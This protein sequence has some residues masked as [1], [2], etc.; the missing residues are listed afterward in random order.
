MTISPLSYTFNEY[1]RWTG[2][3]WG[4]LIN[5]CYQPPDG[6]I[7]AVGRKDTTGGWGGADFAIG[8]MY[9]HTGTGP[10]PLIWRWTAPRAMT[11][12]VTAS[13]YRG[14]F[15]N[16]G[17]DQVFAVRKNNE[18]P[19]FTQLVTWVENPSS[20]PFVQVAYTTVAPGDTLDYVGYPTGTGGWFGMT[21]KIEEV[22][23]VAMP[24]FSPPSGTFATS[25]Q[26][27]I[28]C[29]TVGAAI[30]YTLDGSTPTASSPLYT[31]PIT[32]TATT[33]VKAIGTLTGVPDSPVA[34]A[35]YTK[36]STPVAWN[37]LTDYAPGVL[38]PVQIGPEWAW[39][40]GWDMDDTGDLLSPFSF[41]PMPYYDDWYWGPG[42]HFSDVDPKL[43]GLTNPDGTQ[44]AIHTNSTPNRP[45]IVRW[46]ARRSFT[47]DIAGSVWQPWPNPGD[48]RPQNVGIRK[49][50]GAPIASA[51]ID[52]TVTSTSP[53]TFSQ[54]GIHVE[55]GDVLDF[56]A[57]PQPGMSGHFVSLL[58]TVNEVAG[59]ERVNAPIFSP[60]GGSYTTPQTVTI[61]CPDAA[62]TIHYTTNGLDPT[63]SDPVIASGGTVAINVTTTL[64]ARAFK[65]GWTPSDVTTAVYVIQAAAPVFDPGAGT[66]VTSAQIAMSSATSGAEIRYTT[67]GSEPGAGSTLYTGPVTL[68]ATTT[69]KAKAFK[70]GLDPSPTTSA[71]YT[72][73]AGPVTWDLATD[74]VENRIPPKQIG[75]DWAW[76]YGWDTDTSGTDITDPFVFRSYADWNGMWLGLAPGYDDHTFLNGTP[77]PGIG[78]N[79]GATWTDPDWPSGKVAMHTPPDPDAFKKAA[80][81][82][83]TARRPITVNISGAFW[84]ASFIGNPMRTQVVGL[85]K[86]NETPLLLTDDG[87]EPSSSNPHTFSFTGVNVEPGDNLDFFAGAIAGGI[88]NIVGVDLTISEVAGS[89]RVPAPVINPAG[90]TYGHAVWVTITS[91][92]P[93]ATV[94]YTTD[95]TDPTS[96][97]SGN[98]Y[99]GPIRVA[100]SMTLKARAFKTGMNPST[101]ATAVFTIGTHETW[102][103]ATDYV[104]NRPPAVGFGAEG[105]W[106]FGYDTDATPTSPLA[107]FAFEAYPYFK[108]PW[109]SNGDGAYSKVNMIDQVP[110][111]SKRITSGVWDGFDWPLGKVVHHTPPPDVVGQYTPGIIRWT[112]PRS[113]TVDVSCASWMAVISYRGNNPERYQW[114]TLRKN[115]EAPLFAPVQIGTQDSTA[116]FTFSQA[117]IKVEQGDV[118]DLVAY[119][120]QVAAPIGL[121][122]TITEVPGSE[123]TAAPV[124][125]PGT[126]VYFT[127]P[128]TVTMSCPTL[129]GSTIRYTTNGSD[130]TTSSPVYSGP[131]VISSNTVLKAKAWSPYL[132]ASDVSTATYTFVSETTIGNAKSLPDGTPVGVR[133][134]IAT[135]QYGGDTFYVEEPDRSAGI[136]VHKAYHL[137]TPGTVVDVGGTI[138]TDPTSGERY[139]EATTVST[140]G[141]GTVAPVGLNNRDLGGGGFGGQQ[142]AAG[143][144]GLNNMGLL[145][146]AWGQITQLGTN[147]YSLSDGAGVDVVLLTLGPINI[148]GSNPP[149]PVPDGTYINVTGISTCEKD[150]ISGDI[151]RVIRAVSGGVQV[152]KLP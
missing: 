88:A 101:I 125:T 95:G 81:I 36:I 145:V 46:T 41:Q 121:D 21:Y 8:T 23:A 135:A 149:Q 25:V 133:S 5:G 69:L 92:D 15:E 93:N 107:P 110:G 89:E 19:L 141:T 134:V 3:L 119:L 24:T 42:Y 75:V 51:V 38:P 100:T 142:G 39:S 54:S 71:T 62:A 44:I 143:A 1:T 47:V 53:W 20:H 68:T 16:D 12:R 96:P 99:T 74:W 140:T 6:D 136:R 103:L 111:L 114:L 26:V 11:V 138:Q 115:N 29:S 55:P 13:G 94:R 105:A 144:A 30:H 43:P 137:V 84:K 130:P 31:G 152:I 147:R 49:N 66:F 123:R 132:P 87:D 104:P 9:S 129:G 10:R 150:Q 151:K 86:N 102:D 116:P 58:W 83:W 45:A 59:S 33:T 60:G 64:K 90:G 28:S 56:Y 22:E 76:S 98:A 122:F 146:K 113:I 32:L 120:G 27:S 17:R 124:I 91:P 65:T 52:P 131:I 112:A 108:S 57:A 48:P 37:V 80:I 109:L 106:S 139:I 128:V 78:K 50:S 82:R 77:V 73:V 127:S 117:G 40:Y 118:L 148:P 70:V 2:S 67:D 14:V 97:S 18:P 85:R 79:T 63:T 34:E 72:K 61:T 126:G 7:P 4:V 35:T